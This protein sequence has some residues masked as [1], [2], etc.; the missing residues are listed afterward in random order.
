MQ[1]YEIFLNEQ[2]LRFS[3]RRLA[4]IIKYLKMT[5][6]GFINLLKISFVKYM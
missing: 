2:V 5:S 3:F 1:T 6:F 4:K